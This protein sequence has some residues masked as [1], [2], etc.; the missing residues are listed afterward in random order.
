MGTRIERLKSHIKEN[1]K[2]YIVGGVCFVVG[3]SSTIVLCNKVRVTGIVI[4]KNN[5][6]T[7]TTILI[8]RGHPGN[9]IRCNET[10]EVF[11]SQ[12][13]TASVMGI[14]AARLSEHLSGKRDQVSGY[15][16]EKLGEAS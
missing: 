16:F 14:N 6:L 8:R 13:R 12:G 1:K 15:T 2:V 9:V 10:G 5:T 11:A 3:V 4:G 7:Q